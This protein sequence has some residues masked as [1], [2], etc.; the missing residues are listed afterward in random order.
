MSLLTEKP[1][2]MITGA[3]GYVAGWVVKR[4]LEEGYTVHAPVRDPNNVQKRQHLDKLAENNPGEIKYFKADLLEEGSYN[5]AVKDCSLVIHTASPFNFKAETARE[6]IDPALKGT[7]NVLNSATK[8]G[9]I[10]RIVLTSSCAAMYG[11]AKD[12]KNYKSG[13]ITEEN[14]NTTSSEDHQPYAFSKK[15]AEEVAWKMAEAQDQWRLVTINPAFVMG[16]W[17]TADATS[18]SFDIVK[19]MA[20][21][22]MKAGAPDWNI[23]VV[24]VRNVAEA[25]YR[26]ATVPDA[27]GRHVLSAENSSFIELANMLRENYGENYPLP[28]RTIP[29]W[30]IWLMAPSAGF[31]RKIVSR[32]VGYP[33]KADHSKSVRELNLNYIPIRNTINEMFAQLEESGTIKPKK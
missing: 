30:L 22:D 2:V 4:F 7:Q 8:S 21:G 10:S 20:N 12:L 23:G 14:W 33:W 31:T 29:K 18:G 27:K 13:T 3:T 11:D 15:L 5:E 17:L 28:K 32:N 16:P 24:D 26:A 1:P 19:Q 9:T 25:H 6:F